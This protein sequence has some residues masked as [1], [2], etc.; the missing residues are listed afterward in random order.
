MKQTI[1]DKDIVLAREMTKRF[2]EFIRG[3][4]KD[5]ESKDYK[6]EIVLVIK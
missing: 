2:E 4:V 6:G 1:P 3:K 5:I